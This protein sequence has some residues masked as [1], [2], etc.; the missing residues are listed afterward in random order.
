[1]SAVE[2][3]LDITMGGGIAGM[4]GAVVHARA[5]NRKLTAEADHLGAEDVKV[6]SDTAVLLLKPV[7][8]ALADTQRRC[9]ELKE[10][11]GELTAEVEHQRQVINQMTVKLEAASRRAD[12]YQ[13]AFDERA[14][15]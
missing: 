3:A 1:M 13:K 10:Q 15:K 6:L 14:E 4:F 12:Y 2:V 9:D 8:E 11:V 5:R 7:K